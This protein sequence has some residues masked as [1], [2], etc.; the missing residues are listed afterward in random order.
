MSCLLIFVGMA[1]HCS[2]EVLFNLKNFDL[3]G[4]IIMDE[5]RVETYIS[6]QTPNTLLYRV[7]IQLNLTIYLKSVGCDDTTTLAYVMCLHAASLRVE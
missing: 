7:R 3:C 5:V 6:K 1:G 4:W 2:R